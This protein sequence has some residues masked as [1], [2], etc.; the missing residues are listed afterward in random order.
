MELDDRHLQAALKFLERSQ[1]GTM[2]AADALLAGLHGTDD[3]LPWSRWTPTAGSATCSPARPTAG[4]SR[5]PPRPSFHG[6]LRPYQERGLA[7]LS[8]LGRLGLGGVLADDMGLGKTVADAAPGMTS[9]DQIASAG[10]GC[11]A[12]PTL[13]VCPMSRGGQLAAGG[14]AVHPGA[15]ACT[16]TTART[17]SPARSSPAR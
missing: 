15:A 14:G 11:S 6:E 12:G 5:S 9:G 1:S 4:S 10:P 7:W 8:F 13:L 3:D 16:S 2:Q 17:G